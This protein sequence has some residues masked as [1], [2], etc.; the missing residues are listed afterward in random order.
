MV[1]IIVLFWGATGQLN[2]IQVVKCM[3]LTIISKMFRIWGSG[4]ACVFRDIHYSL[5]AY[6]DSFHLGT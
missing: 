4:I 6:K 5:R 1:A 2:K 3:S